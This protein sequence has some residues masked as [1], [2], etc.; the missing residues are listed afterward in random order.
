MSDWHDNWYSERLLRW[1]CD[2]LF[3]DK[4]DRLFWDETDRL[5]WDETVSDCSETEIITDCS[6]TETFTNCYETEIITDWDRDSQTVLRLRETV[7]C[8]SVLFL[9]ALVVLAG[10]STF[11]LL[12]PVT[13]F[14]HLLQVRSWHGTTCDSLVFTSCN[15]VNRNIISFC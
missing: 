14:T 3:W 6:E 10:F 15:S 1:D 2:R 4:T 9:L 12:Y 5:F 8:V 11:L 7:L 13:F